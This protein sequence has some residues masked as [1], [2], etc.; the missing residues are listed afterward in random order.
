MEVFQMKT[1]KFIVSSS[2]LSAFTDAFENLIFNMRHPKF[3]SAELQYSVSSSENPDF[4]LI[5]KTRDNTLRI[6]I[7]DVGIGA[8]DNKTQATLKALEIA[9]FK[10]KCALCNA[11]RNESDLHITIWND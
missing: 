11:I 3:G 1:I 8:Q 7:K 2:D 4:P 10:M 6:C 5:L 9:G